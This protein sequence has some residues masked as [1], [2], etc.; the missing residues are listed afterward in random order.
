VPPSRAD[1]IAEHRAIETELDA[2]DLRRAAD[3]CRSLYPREQEF[4]GTIHAD[5][6]RKI[7]GQHAEALELAEHLEDALLARRFVAMVQ[8]T[9]IEVERDLFPLR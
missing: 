7:A 3:L 8:H 9:I 2:G 5:A 4:L 6:A 1:L